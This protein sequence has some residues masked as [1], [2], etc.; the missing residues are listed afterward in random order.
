MPVDAG[1]RAFLRGRFPTARDRSLGPPPPALLGRA[2]EG[3][4]CVRCDA[5]CVAACAPAIIRLHPEEH[6]LAGKPYL[7]FEA[8]GCT[9]CYDCVDTCP[10][11]TPQKASSARIGVAVLDWRACIVR[12]GV[13]CMSCWSACDHAAVNRDARGRP[14]IDADACTGCGCCVSV[15]PTQATRI[16]F[17]AE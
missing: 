1:R 11:E 14:G 17:R 3:N 12:D 15:C 2:V 13:I 9:F 16:E 10:L 8:G 7:S 5:P 4:A 6:D